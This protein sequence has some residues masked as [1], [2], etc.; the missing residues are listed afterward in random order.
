MA[1]LQN[2]YSNF[3]YTATGKGMV[4]HALRL[5]G[6]SASGEEPAGG[7]LADCIDT[8]NKMLDGWNAEKL[9]VNALEEFSFTI[10]SRSM[11]VGSG[12]DL[13]MP[14]PNDLGLGQVFLRIGEVDFPLDP[15]R[16]A[17]W[18]MF[19]GLTTS[20]IPGKFYYDRAVPFANLNLDYT[21]DQSYTLILLVP[22]LLRQVTSPSATLRLPPGY[23]E[24]ITYC[25]AERLA[26]EYGKEVPAT[27]VQIAQASRAKI[28]RANVDV[29]RLLPD[30]VQDFGSTGIGISPLAL[31][32]RGQ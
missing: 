14:R 32:N 6:A 31:L 10:N 22:I 15:M 4:K 12:A 7:E 18:G 2:D 20:S 24:A 21:P 5:L 19:A 27:V 26:P 9:S 25:L 8:L 28:Q 3:S 30:S 17:E 23:A 16:A 13:D 11:S 1:V 29:P